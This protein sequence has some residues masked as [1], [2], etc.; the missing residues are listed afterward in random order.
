MHKYKAINWHYIRQSFSQAYI[1]TP[2]MWG[3]FRSVMMSRKKEKEEIK[4]HKNKALQRV[5][6]YLDDLISSTDPKVNSKA[7]KFSYWLEDY[8]KF[9]EFESVFTPVKMRRYKRGEVIKVHLG[10]N[11]GS[12]E[13][14]L[15]YCIVLDK[16][17][18]IKSPVLS[19]VPLTSVKSNTD[20]KKLH[21]G[22]IFLGNELFTHLSSKIITCSNQ[23]KDAIEDLDKQIQELNKRI[24]EDYSSETIEQVEELENCVDELYVKMS[25][26]KRNRELLRE[27]MKEI[28]NMKKGSIALTNQITT[29]SKIR[30]YDPKSNKDVLSNIK[31]SNEKLDLIDNEIGKNY[32]NL[33]K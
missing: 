21:K 27:M 25:K 20:L 32:T 3:F 16:D 1:I 23:T 14:G 7:D 5:D 19:I 2:L 26:I 13:G 12:E 33:L 31:L 22:E 8:I 17:N 30:I 24:D 9:L 11:I 15:H 18:S 29:I 4:E 6:K 28:L 10:Y